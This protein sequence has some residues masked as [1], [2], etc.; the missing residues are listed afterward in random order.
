MLV[1]K[2][3]FDFFVHNFLPLYMLYFVYLGWISTGF[4]PIWK[5]MCGFYERATHPSTHHIEGRG[6]KVAFCLQSCIARLLGSRSNKRDTYMRQGFQCMQYLLAEKSWSR[7]WSWWRDF[8]SFLARSQIEF[9]AK[10]SRWTMD[11]SPKPQVYEDYT[12]LTKLL[13]T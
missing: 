13:H 12:K 7:T 1:K 10:E 6:W 4:H 8:H 5:H 2:I 3:V 9:S 11:I